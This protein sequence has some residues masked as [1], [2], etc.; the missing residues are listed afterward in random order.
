MN[1]RYSQRA[2]AQIADIIAAISIDNPAAA[3]AFARRIETLA[4]RVS[5]HPAMGRQTGL[6]AVRV[7]P[8]KPYPYLPFYQQDTAGTGITVL[9]VRHM[10]RDHDWRE[11]R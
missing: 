10:A 4:V 7:L 6:T 9:R 1:V 2:L 8:T 11:G 3:S 5:R